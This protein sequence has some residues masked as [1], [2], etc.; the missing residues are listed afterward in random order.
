MDD[1]KKLDFLVVQ[2]LFLSDCPVSR[3]GADRHLVG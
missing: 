1:L 3:R 2:E